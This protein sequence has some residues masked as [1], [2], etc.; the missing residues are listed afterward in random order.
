MDAGGPAMKALILL[1]I[2]GGYGNA[3]CGTL[4]LSAIDREPSWADYPRP[5][6]G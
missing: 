3:D 1:G 4:L 6:T 5:K 2:N